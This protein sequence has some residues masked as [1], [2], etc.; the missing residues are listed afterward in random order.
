M[1]ALTKPKK[2]FPLYFFQVSLFRIVMNVPL[3][4]IS[5]KENEFIRF[6]LEQSR[7]VSLM[8][9]LREFHTQKGWCGKREEGSCW[10]GGGMHR[11]RASRPQLSKHTET[12]GGEWKLIVN[13]GRWIEEDNKISLGQEY[14]ILHLQCGKTWEYHGLISLL[15]RLQYLR[16]A[17]DRPLGRT[18]LGCIRGEQDHLVGLDKT[19]LHVWKEEMA[20]DRAIGSPLAIQNILGWIVWLQGDT[21]QNHGV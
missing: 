11:W 12:P 21:F 9:R 16:E 1:S 2:T 15:I 10:K 19:S 4:P 14:I 3:Q 8:L 6:G 13:R 18:P 20:C 5:C 17:R 7:F